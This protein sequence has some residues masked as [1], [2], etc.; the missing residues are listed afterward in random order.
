[1]MSVTGY[2]PPRHDASLHGREAQPV[3]DHVVVARPIPSASC[4]AFCTKPAQVYLEMSFGALFW[5]GRHALMNLRDFP[6]KTLDERG[7]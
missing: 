5:C 3:T 2:S 6:A 1:M 4:C 7:F